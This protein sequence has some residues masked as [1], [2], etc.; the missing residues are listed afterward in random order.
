MNN[1][2]NFIYDL[3]NIVRK[4]QHNEQSTQSFLLNNIEKYFIK[5][6]ISLDFENPYLR[7]K[8]LDSLRVFGAIMPINN[9]I[10]E[11]LYIK[12][13]D[14]YSPEEKVFWKA[15]INNILFLDSYLDKDVKLN[16]SN[17]I[18]NLLLEKNNMFIKEIE[19]TEYGIYTFNEIEK[20]IK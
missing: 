8:A 1:L 13:F 7:Y 11:D 20:L 2:I 17:N 3:K 6:L 4:K 16:I 12:Y 19:K 5:S 15:G 14:N 18:K 9:A 10:G